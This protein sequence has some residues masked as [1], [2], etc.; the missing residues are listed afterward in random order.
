MKKLELADI[1]VDTCMDA[2]DLGQRIVD[3]FNKLS[4]D[5]KSVN[6]IKLHISD[7]M[8]VNH[9]SLLCKNIIKSLHDIGAENCVI[10]PIKKGFIEDV[11]I[12][13][14]IVD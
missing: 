4:T 6:L 2:D 5:Y 10:V 1:H 7:D 12:D 8:S 3:C 11:T 13:H 14:I 9:A